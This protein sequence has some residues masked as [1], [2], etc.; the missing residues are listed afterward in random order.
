M[1]VYRLVAA[2]LL[3]FLGS[4]GL[5][6]A[7]IPALRALNLRQQVRTDGPRRHLSKMGTPTMGGLVLLVAIPFGAL[8]AS[9][10]GWEVW[11]AVLATV[12]Y[13]V[14]GFLDDF[15]KI[16]MRRPLGL[17]ARVKLFLQVVL[18][19]A[20]GYLGVLALGLDTRVQFPLVG[21]SIDF[22][23]LY[24][25]FAASVVIA[26]ANAV[27]LT[28]GLDGLAAGTVAIAAAAY[29]LVSLAVERGGLALFAAALAGGCVGFLRYNWHPARVFMGDTG[30]L[31]L[32]AALG[33]LAVLTK[34]ELLLLIVGGVFV[35]ETLS[36]MIQ[37][38]VFQT[39]GRRVFR[40]SPLHHHFELAGLTEVE[41]VK[42]FWLAAAVL[43]AA[44]FA[45]LG[46]MGAGR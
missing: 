5:G 40:M 3:A 30:A 9:G 21:R 31:G 43:A 29:V 7:V 32:G 18:A 14:I 26:S 38:V 15:L 17:R 36:V 27:N 16:V 34:T 12:G 8:V 6:A 28:D 35:A 33:A 20:V 42:R 24:V 41:V 39:T 22:G 4:L 23:Q 19:V 46:G 11:L 1:P 10:G 2:A 13:G 44:G 25:P 45:T 37:V